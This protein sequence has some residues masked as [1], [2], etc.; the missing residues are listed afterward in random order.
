MAEVKLEMN[1]DSWNA[2]KQRQ[3]QKPNK[4]LPM[5]KSSKWKRLILCGTIGSDHGRTAM[6]TANRD[7]DILTHKYENTLSMSEF[8]IVKIKTTTKKKQKQNYVT[9]SHFIF[10]W[11]TELLIGSSPAF[12]IIYVV[13]FAFDSPIYSHRDWRNSWWTPRQL[14]FFSW[15]WIFRV[16]VCGKATFRT[17]AIDDVEHVTLFVP[18]WRPCSVYASSFLSHA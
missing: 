5:S 13:V 4:T 14:A 12:S 15:I 10:F 11:A 1:N 9:I 6:V 7:G 3:Q 17:N 16:A 18:V 8:A 2:T